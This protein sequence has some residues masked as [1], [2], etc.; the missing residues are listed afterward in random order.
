MLLLQNA[1]YSFTKRKRAGL[2]LA[3]M[4]LALLGRVLEMT[5]PAE[6]PRSWSRRRRQDTAVIC[7]AI[8]DIATAEGPVT[9]RQLFYRLVSLGLIPKT[10]AAYDRTVVR[11]CKEMRLDGDLPWWCI[12]DNS[13]WMRKPDTYDG[14]SSFLATAAASYRRA[15]W[16]QGDEYV[17]VWLEKEALSGVLHPLTAEWDVPLMVT[18]GYPSLTFL[19]EAAGELVLRDQDV[20]IYYL[21]DFDP[22]GLD[23]PRNVEERLWE[24]GADISRFER[25][26]V[27]EQQITDWSLQTRPTKRSQKNY[28]AVGFSGDSVEVD[29]I[30]PAQLVELVEQAILSHVDEEAV[31]KLREVE[32][33]EREGLRKLRLRE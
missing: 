32:A 3:S 10:E 11:L 4:G 5:D 24:F 19:H 33:S 26:A 21:G 2:G 30:P 23:I 22:S 17:E 25:L 15:L 12:A 27:T 13:R 16:E 28:L 9:V 18:R 6:E 29:A 7:E 20:T 14:V 8:V 1:N 31:E